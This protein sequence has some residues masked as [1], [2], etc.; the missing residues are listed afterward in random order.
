MPDVVYLFICPLLLYVYL[1]LHIVLY[2]AECLRM[3]T[4]PFANHCF[5]IE[6]VYLSICRPMLYVR[7]SIHVHFSTT[8]V[9]YRLSTC[10]LVF[11]YCMST[12]PFAILSR[13][14]D[15]VIISFTI[16]WVSDDVYLSICPPIVCQKMCSLVHFPLLLRMSTFPFFL[17]WSTIT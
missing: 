17:C 9:C 15:Y 6:V 3:T 4:C 7:G 11:H 13:T 8:S 1:Y 5:M 10:S 16:C 12:Y 14:S 2:K